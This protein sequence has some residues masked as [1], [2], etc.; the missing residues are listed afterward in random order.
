MVCAGYVCFAIN[1]QTLTWT[2]GFLSCTQV[3]T[4][5]IAHE[6]VWTPK[7]SL[8]WKLTLERKSL[9]TPWNWTCIS[10]MLVRC[11]N[12]LSYIP[13]GQ[14]ICD[15]LVKW[16]NRLPSM[17]SRQHSQPYGIGKW[18]EYCRITNIW[19]TQCWLIQDVQ[20]ICNMHMLVSSV[21][22][23]CMGCGLIGVI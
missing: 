21:E 22:I 3:L 9:A 20:M 11:S 16:L 6:G 1:H 4:Q 8:H 19:R 14:I 5:A 7:E 10:G 2:R 17:E 18:G 12:Q 15:P 23:N 13:S